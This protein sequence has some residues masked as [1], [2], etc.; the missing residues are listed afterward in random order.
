MSHPFCFIHKFWFVASRTTT[1]LKK[2]KSR[3]RAE[4]SF[5]HWHAHLPGRSHLTHG[6]FSSV[7]STVFPLYLVLVAEIWSWQC[8]PHWVLIWVTMDVISTAWAGM[9]QRGP[10]RKGA[11]S[12]LAIIATASSMYFTWLWETLPFRCKSPQRKKAKTS[13]TAFQSGWATLPWFSVTSYAVGGEDSYPASA[14]N[15]G[16]LTPPGDSSL[17]VIYYNTD[18][19]MSVREGSRWESLLLFSHAFFLLILEQLIKDRYI[20]AYLDLLKYK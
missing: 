4:A 8:A 16:T 2:Q 9:V 6:I 7:V 1:G 5:R 14:L 11:I 18:S 15:V 13:I 3:K 19:R 12:S 17:T 10:G 20:N